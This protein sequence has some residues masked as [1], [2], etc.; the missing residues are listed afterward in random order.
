MIRIEKLDSEVLGAVRQSLGADDED[1]ESKD[2]QIMTM[3]VETVF[4]KYLEWEG[5][6][7]YTSS[8][9]NAIDNIRA[10]AKK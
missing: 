6:I 5:I 10:A 8:I 4:R 1:D 7:G 2:D 9:L 3:D